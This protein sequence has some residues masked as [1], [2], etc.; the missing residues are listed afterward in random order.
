MPLR[1]RF[2]TV[3]PSPY[4]RELFKALHLDKRVD[5]QV[6]YY[7]ESASDRNWSIAPLSSY[8]KILRGTTL[9]WLGS[10]AHLNYGI[11]RLL[12]EDCSDIFVISDYS[13]PSTQIAMRLLTRDRKPWVFWGEVPGLNQRGR[14]GT[15]LRR[16]LQQ[17]ILDGATAVAAIGSEAVNAYKK[18]FLGLPVFD[19]PYF[20]DLARFKSAASTKVVSEKHT[21]DILFS[22]QLTKRKG[23]DILVHAFLQVSDFVPQLRLRIVGVGP[24]LDTLIDIIPTRSRHRVEFLGFQQ[25]AA[26]PEIF[27][28]SDI[29]V[30]PSRHDGWGVVVNEALGAGLPIVLS[31]RVGARDLVEDGRNG[32]IVPAGSVDPLANALLKLGQSVTMRRAFG[33]VSAHR[34][35]SWDIDEGVSRWVNLFNSVLKS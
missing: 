2:L 15:V 19:V 23:I 35:K 18:L 16:K 12:K 21:V 11:A 24:E 13:A 5:I 29:F 9:N 28:A 1:V 33:C 17:P 27:A 32:F 22:G 30:L 7:T 25:P 14:L 4:Q 6:W 8:E 10:S 20:C 26:L 31:D 34:S 3:M